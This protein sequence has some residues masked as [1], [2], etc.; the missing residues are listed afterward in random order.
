MV[1]F[2]QFILKDSE[3]KIKRYR[4]VLEAFERDP[5][6]LATEIFTG[7]DFLLP[8][9]VQQYGEELLLEMQTYFYTRF[10]PVFQDYLGADGVVLSYDETVFPSPIRMDYR[11]EPLALVNIV[12]KEFKTLETERI[13]QLKEEV[14]RLEELIEQTENELER[15]DSALKNPLVLGGAN[16]LK[17]MDIA[18][19]KET[20]RA[21]IR[22]QIAILQDDLFDYD[23]RRIRI[24][25]AIDAERRENYDRE[26]LLEKIEYKL[27]LLPGFQYL[28]NREESEEERLGKNDETS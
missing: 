7:D 10:L 23:Q 27:R 22:S 9:V 26:L 21:R 4:G 8:L 24:L 12:T 18:I 1:D 3:E 6:I 11:E 16:P 15:W 2:L 17:L 28:K 5:M 25:D 14:R 19:R 13:V 20:Y